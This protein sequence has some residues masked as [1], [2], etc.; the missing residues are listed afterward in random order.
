LKTLGG[1]TFPSF[2]FIVL[3]LWCFF[4][5]SLCG[6]SLKDQFFV[7]FYNISQIDQLQGRK[8]ARVSFI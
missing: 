5:L 1:V 6:I 2:F 8:F 3:L 4:F 7:I